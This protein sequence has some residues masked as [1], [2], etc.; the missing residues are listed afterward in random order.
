MNKLKSG[1]EF[2]TE[3]SKTAYQSGKDA[4]GLNEEAPPTTSKPMTI[5]KRVFGKLADG[6]KVH[7][8]RLINEQGMEVSIIEYGA[9]IRD[10]I[11]PGPGWRRRG[12]FP[13]VL[14]ICR[15][16]WKRV[17]TLDVLP[18]AMPTA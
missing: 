14:I 9:A 1:G 2:L 10:I 6:S 15:T 8:F 3:K 13:W 7:E 16:M 18:D 4:L 5:S 17:P 11:V 12:M